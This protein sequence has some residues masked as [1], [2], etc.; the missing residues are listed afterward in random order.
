VEIVADSADYCVNIETT[1]F[2]DGALRGQ[3]AD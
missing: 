1:E 2:T 3:L